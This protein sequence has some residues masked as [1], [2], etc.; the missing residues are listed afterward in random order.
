M[1]L[2][3]VLS[4]GPEFLQHGQAHSNIFCFPVLWNRQLTLHGCFLFSVCWEPLLCS[5]DTW[6]YLDTFLHFEAFDKIHCC[7]TCGSHICSVSLLPF[8][9]PQWLSAGSVAFWELLW[10]P[11][12]LPAP[13]WCR[14]LKSQ[15]P[16]SL[17]WAPRTGY[18]F[19]P[20]EEY[21]PLAQNLQKCSALPS[22]RGTRCF[23]T[24]LLPWSRWVRGRAAL[25]TPGADL[26]SRLHNL[27]SICLM[28]WACHSQPGHNSQEQRVLC[29]S[30]HHCASAGWKNQV[31]L[32]PGSVIL[33]S[34]RG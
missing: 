7:P 30:D 1:I 2:V 19:L 23:R 17:S 32:V 28:L 25:T 12:F 5:R 20:L 13:W 11:V 21:C 3:S 14:R 16:L 27:C 4:D 22:Q 24:H 31:I 6:R 10:P 26:D 8:L 29:L 33:Q 15:H 34:L 9:H 18:L